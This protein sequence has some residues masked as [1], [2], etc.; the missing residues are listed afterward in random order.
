M[1]RTPAFTCFSE[2]KDVFSV[3]P[4]GDTARFSRS[5]ADA[6]VAESAGS[7]AP[8]TPTVRILENV[9]LSIGLTFL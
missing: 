5:G 2:P 1:F 9:R 3:R 7:E 6:D 4:V 8:A